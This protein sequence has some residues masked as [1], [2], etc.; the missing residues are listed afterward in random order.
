MNRVFWDAM[1]F[2]YLLEGHR[3]YQPMVRELLERSYE[4]EDVLL[5]SYLVLAEL[6]VGPEYQNQTV[7]T[8]VAT[9]EEMGFSFIEFGRSSVE[10]FRMLRAQYGLRGP[11]AIHLSCAAAA[12]VDLFLTG[13]EQLLQKRLRIP[14]IRFIATFENAPI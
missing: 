6:M 13:D 5:T 3:K 8:V 4:R 11:D 1:L 10:P 7:E 2:V 12:K 9:L 14:G